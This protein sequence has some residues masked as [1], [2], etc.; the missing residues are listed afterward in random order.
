MFF[1]KKKPEICEQEQKAKVKA[2]EF[3]RAHNKAIEFNQEYDQYSS[4]LIT[5]LEEYGGRN[6]GD[7]IN[8]HDYKGFVLAVNHGKFDPDLGWYS[9][10]VVRPNIVISYRDQSG[11]IQE[12][13]LSGDRLKQ[14]IRI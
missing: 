3:E 10:R 11:H 8:Y 1:K 4:E 5:F 2:E 14:L 9:H 12:V 6:P 7:R 13:R